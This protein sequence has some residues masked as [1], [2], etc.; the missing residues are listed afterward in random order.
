[1]LLAGAAAW[2]V[3]GLVVVAGLVGALGEVLPAVA[4]VVLSS[5]AAAVLATIGVVRAR[6]RLREL[7]VLQGLWWAADLSHAVVASYPSV[8][9]RLSGRPVWRHVPLAALAPSP[10][11]IARARSL[12]LRFP[13]LHRNSWLSSDGERV[14]VSWIVRAAGSLE[15]P[16]ETFWEDTAIGHALLRMARLAYRRRLFARVQTPS[17]GPFR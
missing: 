11:D 13:L 8:R 12:R 9:A 15:I 6:A 3:P 4:W 16:F 5:L 17:L 2:A 1:L 14:D 10:E 7:E